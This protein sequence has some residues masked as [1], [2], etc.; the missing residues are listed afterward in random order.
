MD[1][2]LSNNHAPATG[3]AHRSVTPEVLRMW[4]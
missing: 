3:A 4:R 2:G 1:S